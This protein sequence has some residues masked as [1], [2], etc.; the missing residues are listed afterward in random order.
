MFVIMYCTSGHDDYNIY[1]YMSSYTQ[2]GTAKH[3]FYVKT[4]LN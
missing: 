2:C 1:F 4:N 3:F